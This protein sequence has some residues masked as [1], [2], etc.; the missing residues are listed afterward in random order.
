MTYLEALEKLKKYCSYQERCHHE[1]R[2]KLLSLKVYGDTLEQ[3]MAT[4]IEE[5]YL[6]EQR[7][8]EAYARGKYRIK[9]WGKIKI[10]QRL[11]AKKVSSYCIKKALQ[12]LEEE[13]GY[14]E[15]LQEILH[16]YIDQRREKY[17]LPILRKKAYLYGISKGYEPLLV[18]DIVS[19]LLQE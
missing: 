6:N 12:A 17:M 18:G 13:G 19:R 15:G 2:G 10:Q 5:N 3:V 4:L 14:E 11:K 16:S 7:F 1:A 8:A 9:R